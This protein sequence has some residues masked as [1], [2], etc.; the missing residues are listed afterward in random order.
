MFFVSCSL[1]FSAIL[2]INLSDDTMPIFTLS[3][4]MDLPHLVLVVESKR[5]IAQVLPGISELTSLS[6]VVKA[7]ALSLA[8]GSL[9][10][11]ILTLS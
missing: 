2:H 4:G 5:E 6:Y 9:S 3:Q 10:K 11:N 8:C 1:N 7:T